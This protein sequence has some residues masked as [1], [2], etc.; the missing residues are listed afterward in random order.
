MFILNT[1]NVVV[2]VNPER[3]LSKNG[4]FVYLIHIL[5]YY[6]VYI[7]QVQ[8]LV[9]ERIIDRFIPVTPKD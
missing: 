4:V 9:S 2:A 6:I 3:E 1:I 7:V 8:L 5:Y